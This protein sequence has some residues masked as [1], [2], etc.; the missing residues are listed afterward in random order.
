MTPLSGQQVYSKDGTQWLGS[1]VA[2]SSLYC[3][4]KFLVLLTTGGFNMVLEWD[5]GLG[6]WLAL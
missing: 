6:G 3:R 4:G 2:H 5:R 1:V